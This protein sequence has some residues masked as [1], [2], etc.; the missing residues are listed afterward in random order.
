MRVN[1]VAFENSL[2]WCS[3]GPVCSENSGQLAAILSAACVAGQS[4]FHHA[5]LQCCAVAWLPH[6]CLPVLT[7]P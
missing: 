4:G 6:D 3:S 7:G 1:V 5:A 2:V